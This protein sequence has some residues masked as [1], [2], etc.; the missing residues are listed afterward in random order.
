MSNSLLYTDWQFLDIQHIC[1]FYQQ[2]YHCHHKHIRLSDFLVWV[3][4]FLKM[5]HNH[6][7][8]PLSALGTLSILFLW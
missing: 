7:E 5:Y 4:Y 6:N 2:V 1:D 3:P 8:K